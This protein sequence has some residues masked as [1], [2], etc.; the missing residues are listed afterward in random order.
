MLSPSPEI[1]D[2]VSRL[3]G[4]PASGWRPVEGGYTPAR[5]YVVEGGGERMFVKVASTPLT[6][7]MLRR[8]GRSYAQ[9]SGMFIPHL[10]AWEDHEQEPIL[11]IE[12][13]SE[14]VWPPP[15]N[16]GRVDVVL[17]AIAAMHAT[18]ADLPLLDAARAAGEPGWPAVAAQPGPFLSLGL[19][20]REWLQRSLPA[21]VEAEQA[22]EL[23]GQALTHLDLRSDNICFTPASAVFIDWAEA[24]LSNPEVDLGFWLPSLAYEGGP[25]PDEILPAAPQVAALVSGFFAARAGLP[26]IPDAPFVRRVQREQLSTALPWAARA[27]GLEA[28]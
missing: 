1:Q 27:L 15:W 3:I 14:A 13:L 10:I 20:S 7:A 4:R 9:V 25:R 11:I 28:P 8:E 22:C 26:D 23:T 6:A 5:R 19:A 24:C 21:L 17:E 16:E 2:R 12:D 18:P